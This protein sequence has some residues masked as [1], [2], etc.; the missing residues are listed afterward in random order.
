[1]SFDLTNFQVGDEF[2]TSPH[3]LGR[4]IS[5]ILAEEGS[6]SYEGNSIII[7]S[8]PKRKTAEPEYVFETPKPIEKKADVIASPKVEEVKEEVVVKAPKQIV[9]ETDSETA[10]SPKPKG[11]PRKVVA[12]IE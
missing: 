4:I 10:L 6:F 2:E 8:L 5:A 12:E 3:E 9:E 11:R 7:T 1:M